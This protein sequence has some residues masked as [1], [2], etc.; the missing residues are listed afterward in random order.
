[1]ND[2]VFCAASVSHIAALL[3]ECHTAIVKSPHL[4]VSTLK[5]FRR[6]GH[7]NGVTRSVAT[8][9]YVSVYHSYQ[10]PIQPPCSVFQI[11]Q[12]YRRP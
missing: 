3:V 1:M 5:L 11:P 7:S 9:M 2:K 8:Y 4:D 6:A 10:L 12:Q